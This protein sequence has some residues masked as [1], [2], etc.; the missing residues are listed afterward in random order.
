MFFDIEVDGEPE[1]GARRW[2]NRKYTTDGG[3][4]HVTRHEAF[5]A[6]AIVGIKCVV[7]QIISTD[8]LWSL[9]SLAGRYKG[10]SPFQPATWGRFEPHDIAPRRPSRTS[11]PGTYAAAPDL[12]GAAGAK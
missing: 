12:D 6:Q 1:S 9:W 10:I 4:T 11:K 2:Y 3:A 7:P 8:D 5:H